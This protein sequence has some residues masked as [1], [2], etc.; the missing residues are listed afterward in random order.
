MVGSLSDP[1]GRVTI[2]GVDGIGQVKGVVARCGK[3]VQSRCYSNPYQHSSGYAWASREG[4]SVGGTVAERRGEPRSQ[5]TNRDGID[6]IYRR[7]FR[8]FGIAGSNGKKETM[9]T[10]W[11]EDGGEGRE[12]MSAGNVRRAVTSR[13]CFVSRDTGVSRSIVF[14]P[15]SWRPWN[16]KAYIRSPVIFLCRLVGCWAIFGT[17][18]GRGTIGIA[19]YLTAATIHEG[20]MT[21][22]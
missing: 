7:N 16:V 14:D 5:L 22:R 17:E 19:K 12:H 9:E 21:Q 1:P 11:I 13:F 15:P 10:I 2:N 3:F 4:L 6:R 18:N 8:A 20:S